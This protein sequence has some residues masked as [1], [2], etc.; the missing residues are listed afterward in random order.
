MPALLQQLASVA[1]ASACLASFVLSF[2][3]TFRLQKGLACE[4]P[5]PAYVRHCADRSRYV[6]HDWFKCSTRGV[7]SHYFRVPYCWAF[8][9]I[10]ILA[11]H[12][13]R[14]VDPVGCALSGF[15]VIQCGHN[16]YYCCRLQHPEISVDGS[17][18]RHK[19]QGTCREQHHRSAISERHFIWWDGKSLWFVLSCSTYRTWRKRPR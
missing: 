12:V 10:A 6:H 3:R 14:V 1:V 9:S 4:L 8:K 18:R 7:L 5:G 15:R 17:F 2:R 16:R 19:N 11:H 13:L